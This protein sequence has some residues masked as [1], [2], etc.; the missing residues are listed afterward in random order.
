MLAALEGMF[1]VVVVN[2]ERSLVRASKH[3][4]YEVTQFKSMHNLRHENLVFWGEG[5]IMN[6]EMVPHLDFLA[7]SMRVFKQ[8]T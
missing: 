8:I 3:T 7:G 6:I 5:N 1:C 2:Q 4:C